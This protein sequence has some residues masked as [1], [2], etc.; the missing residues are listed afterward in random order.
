MPLSPFTRLMWLLTALVFPLVFLTME[1]R[2]PRIA[3][4]LLGIALLLLLAAVFLTIR[5]GGAFDERSFQR[6]R[7]LGERRVFR[8]HT[9]L[10]LGLAA[11]VALLAVARGYWLNLGWRAAWAAGLI[12]WV[13]VLLVIAAAATGF[14]LAMGRSRATARVVWIL[15]GLPAGMQLGLM[16]FAHR[17]PGSSAVGWTSNLNPGEVTALA[18]YLLAWWLA[19]G[20]GNWRAGLLVAAIAGGSLPLLTSQGPL[21]GH[22]PAPLAEAAVH[23]ERQAPFR[24]PP[25]EGGTAAK[26]LRPDWECFRVSGL[27]RDEYLWFSCALPLEE[28]IFPKLPGDFRRELLRLFASYRE[29]SIPMPIDG[30]SAGLA[31]CGDLPG[32]PLDQVIPMPGRRSGVSVNHAD[33]RRVKDADWTIKGGIS[34]ITRAGSVP[35]FKGGRLDFPSGGCVRLSP[36][37]RGRDERGDSDIQ[38]DV[39]V[40][41][42]DHRF[43]AQPVT[44]PRFLHSLFEYCKMVVVAGDGRRAVVTYLPQYPRICFGLGSW[45]ES[46]RVS[47]KPAQQM[48][49]WSPADTADAT[50]HCFL[51]HPVG[52]VDRVLPPPRK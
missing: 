3:N 27:Q 47:I 50:V 39:L 12:V 29:E 4:T 34:R 15:L 48:A 17:S 35:L 40:T 23:I 33:A 31:V 8:Q 51:I 16:E 21:L 42:P 22:L 32:W 28:N 14:T 1:A 52:T 11:G 41:V 7:P 26:V 38:F 36:A 37:R 13:L 18:G 6:T 24:D 45:W 10:G 2:N 43:A 49:D 46:N 20:R 5:S 30:W 19:A 44:D 9:L 25:G